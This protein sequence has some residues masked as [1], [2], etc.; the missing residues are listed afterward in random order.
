MEILLQLSIN[1]PMWYLVGVISMSFQ[2][3]L[4]Y[5]HE[6]KGHKYT[7]G[8]RKYL[9]Y[10]SVIFKSIWLSSKWP[11]LLFKRDLVGLNIQEWPDKEQAKEIKRL[12]LKRK[13]R[14]L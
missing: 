3:I 14:N 8:I 6:I 13:L 11:Y 1:V 4:S 7:R 9:L 10:C 12:K 2:L 5:I